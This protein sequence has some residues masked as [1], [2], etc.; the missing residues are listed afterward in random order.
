MEKRNAKND[1]IIAFWKLYEKKRIE[2]ISI[3]EL[4][5]TTGYNRTTFYVYFHN[6]Y[7]LLDEAIINLLSPIKENIDCIQ[8][9]IDFS[10]M[11][12]IFLSFFYEN[13]KCIQLILNN[14]HHY[15]LEDRAK[16]II[17]PMLK[18]KL[19]NQASHGISMDYIIEYQISAIFGVLRLWFWDSDKKISKEELAHILFEISTKG[20]FP[21]LNQ[22][23]EKSKLD[24][25]NNDKEIINDIKYKDNYK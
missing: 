24:P 25:L 13:D 10:S 19:I 4:S 20:V 17:I 23:F 12:K 22:K 8:N 15:I 14:N 16:E 5:Q 6:I 3:R 1:F 18:D 21:I 2:K 11:E 7:D 9:L